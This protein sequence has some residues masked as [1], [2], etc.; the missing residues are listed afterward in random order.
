MTF[1]T[2]RVILNIRLKKEVLFMELSDDLIAEYLTPAHIWTKIQNMCKLVRLIKK[3]EERNEPYTQKDLAEQLNLST[4][5]VF[6]Y[7]Q[8]LKKIQI[9]E[10]LKKEKILNEKLSQKIGNI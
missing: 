10:E 3:Y 1:I 4:M 9:C 8:D 6:R 5:T 2:Y 7:M